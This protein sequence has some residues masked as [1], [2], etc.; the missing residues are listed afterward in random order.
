MVDIS[1][2]LLK[3]FRQIMKEEY[4]YEFKNNAEAHEAASNL[5]GYF[6]LLLKIEARSREEEKMKK[7]K[8][9]IKLISVGNKK[10]QQERR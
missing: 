8:M 10:E 4:N 1:P 5:V 9:K 6:D 3:E 2:K 7:K